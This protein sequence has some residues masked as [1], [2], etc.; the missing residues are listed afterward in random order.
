MHVVN[1]FCDGIA[2]VVLRVSAWEVREQVHSCF[3]HMC[4]KQTH[5][6]E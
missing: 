4:D 6:V 1:G 5:C 2:R 3:K